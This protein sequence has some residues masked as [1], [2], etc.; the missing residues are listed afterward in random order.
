MDWRIEKIIDLIEKDTH[1]EPSFKGIAQSMNLS[2]SRLR[3]LFKAETGV[4]PSQ[5]LRAVRMQKA[6]Q[7][8]ENTFMSVKEIMI[9]VGFND[10]SHFVR[11]FKRVYGM[12]PNKYRAYY[13]STLAKAVKTAN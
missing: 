1:L 8:L 6:K 5:Y 4:S 10:E 9:K 2:Y 7:H 13:H 12:P 11:D 3:Y